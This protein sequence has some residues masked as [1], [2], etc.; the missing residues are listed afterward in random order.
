MDNETIWYEYNI[1]L[2]H[3]ICDFI[4]WMNVTCYEIKSIFYN[5][6]TVTTVLVL[7]INRLYLYKY[8]YTR[9]STKAPLKLFLIPRYLRIISIIAIYCSCI[10]CLFT[11]DF[12]P[13][14]YIQYYTYYVILYLD[15]DTVHN[16]LCTTH[17]Q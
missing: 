17:F 15:C 14:T 6:Q 10:F 16:I 11:L 4:A 12:S 1:I 5:T 9:T 2:R 7:N 13:K 3:S 8:F